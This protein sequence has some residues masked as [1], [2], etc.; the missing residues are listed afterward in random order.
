[1]NA[2]F[3][4]K[5]DKGFS[6]GLTGPRF[7]RYDGGSFSSSETST[8]TQK[9]IKDSIL[10]KIKRKLARCTYICIK[11]N[12]EKCIVIFCVEKELS[13]YGRTALFVLAEKMQ[14]KEVRFCL[15]ISF[16]YHENGL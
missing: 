7:V 6:E 3:N 1:M 11:K 15:C 10:L 13:K 4:A 2:N 16:F 14:T 9:R 5:I 8:R 12:G